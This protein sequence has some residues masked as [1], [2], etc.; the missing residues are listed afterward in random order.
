MSQ[1]VDLKIDL[2]IEKGVTSGLSSAKSVS[3][4]LKSIQLLKWG[5]SFIMFL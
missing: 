2:Q 3:S 4:F 5:I 1:S